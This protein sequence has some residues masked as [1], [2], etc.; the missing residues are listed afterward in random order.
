MTVT[1]TTTP[2]LAQVRALSAGDLVTGFY[3]LTKCETRKKKDGNPFLTICLQDA[4]GSLDAKKWEE[5]NEFYTEAKIGDVVKVEGRVDHYNNVPSLIIARI[6]VATEEEATDKRMYLP[7]SKLSAEDARKELAALI[8][9]IRNPNLLKVLHAVF[10][11]AEFM[12]RFLDAPGGKKWHHC[13]MG[14]LAEHTISLAKLADCV[15]GL[16]GELDRD[17]LLTGAL[18]HDIGKVF[19]L[20]TDIAFDYTS[21]GRLLGHITEGALYVERKLMELEDFPAETRKHVLHLMLSHHGGEPGIGSPVRPSTL[22]ALVLHFCDEIDSQTAA[23][24]RE[25]EAAEGQE[26][27]YIRLKD[28]HYYFKRIDSYEETTEG[29]S[30]GE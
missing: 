20:S 5:F 3:L 4:T 17:L 13:S 27:S 19:E 23:F 11:D 30:D 15:A 10:D 26:I 1:A 7:H 12:E 6:R 21:E 25:R 14:G 2:P 16:Y 28:Q 22:E 9:S 24:L 8:N 29:D 18:L